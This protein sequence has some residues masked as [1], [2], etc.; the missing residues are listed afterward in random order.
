MSELQALGIAGL[1]VL[2]IDHPLG[3]E[4]PAGVLR[5]AHQAFE[6]LAG[7]VGPAE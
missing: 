4:L 1:P 7:L 3:G 5:R 2:I 6:Q